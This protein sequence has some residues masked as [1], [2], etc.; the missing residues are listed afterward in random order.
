[1][2]AASPARRW[3]KCFSG[4]SAA[5]S[6][7]H[8]QRRAG[9]MIQK[10]HGGQ[11]HVVPYGPGTPGYL[12]IARAPISVP[13]IHTDTLSLTSHFSAAVA[14]PP[15]LSFVCAGY[16]VHLSRRLAVIRGPRELLR[17]GH[18]SAL[19]SLAQAC[20]RSGT[21]APSRYQKAAPFPRNR[22]R[23]SSPAALF[24]A[25]AHLPSPCC[26]PWSPFQLT[27]L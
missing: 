24:F 14:V 18:C 25:L 21:P 9:R 17:K 10:S 2:R 26:P 16:A 20:P 1:M 6:S 5:G 22:P 4:L 13:Y 11:V 3:A 7:D 23:R 27:P 8:R 19:L 15:S 12:S